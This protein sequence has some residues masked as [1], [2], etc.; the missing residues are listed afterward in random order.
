M[1]TLDDYQDSD[2]KKSFI[3]NNLKEAVTPI[4]KIL[5]PTEMEVIVMEKFQK[6]LIDEETFEKAMDEIELLKGGAGSGRKSSGST[7][8]EKADFH[9]K[10]FVEAKLKGDKK[11][12]D[13]HRAK[14]SEHFNKVLDEE[15]SKHKDAADAKRNVYKPNDSDTKWQTNESAPN[16]RGSNSRDPIH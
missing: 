1:I 13:K 12:E 14:Y 15:A 2:I 6:S 5:T 7:H 4:K 8:T 16:S 10:K 11:A 9:K 3:E